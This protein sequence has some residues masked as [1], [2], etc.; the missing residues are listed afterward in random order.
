VIPHD[1]D[2]SGRPNATLSSSSVEAGTETNITV[3]VTD[4]SGTPISGATVSIPDLN[5]SATTDNNGE[6]TLSVNASATG[7]YTVTA[8]A[9]DFAGTTAVL[10]VLPADDPV[11]AVVGTTP[12][13]DLDSDGRYEDINGDGTFNIVDVN[14]LYQSLGS[15]TLTDNAD[16]FDFNGDGSVNIVDV[17]RLFQSLR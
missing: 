4:Y 9:D 1:S 5:Q 6:A 13:G 17:N 14:A 16:A 10:T 2:L 11:P 15:E 12:A 3:T 7:N 8:S